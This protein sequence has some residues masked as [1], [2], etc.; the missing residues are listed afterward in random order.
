[1]WLADAPFWGDLWAWEA[2]FL[3]FET[4]SLYFNIV[5]TCGDSSVGYKTISR[6]QTISESDFIKAMEPSQFICCLGNSALSE[7]SAL[8]A[9][10]DK[11]VC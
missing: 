2:I 11:L 8:L 4:Q 6:A 7:A 5:L 3:I 1:M 9:T 10:T